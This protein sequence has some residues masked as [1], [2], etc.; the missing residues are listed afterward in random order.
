MPQAVHQGQATYSGFFLTASREWVES[1]STI[2]L[3]SVPRQ[4]DGHGHHVAVSQPLLLVGRVVQPA[5]AAELQKAARADGAI[6]Y[7]V[8]RMQVYAVSAAL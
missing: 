6:A 1:S 3:V 7:H 4:T 5:G 8:A 2:V